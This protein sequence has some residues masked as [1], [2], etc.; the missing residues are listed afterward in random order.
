MKTEFREEQINAIHPERKFIPEFA[1]VGLFKTGPVADDKG[2]P[3]L[4]NILEPGQA[5]HALAPPGMEISSRQ[6]RGALDRII[7]AA[8]ELPHRP[9][10]D[11][12]K[13]SLHDLFR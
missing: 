2:A 9:G 4:V 5:T 7:C 12:F 11:P 6:S 8:R 3:A 1:Q 10:N 13:S